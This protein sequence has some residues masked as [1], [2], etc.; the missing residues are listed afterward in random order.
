MKIIATTELKKTT[1]DQPTNKIQFKTFLRHSLNRIFPKLNRVMLIDSLNAETN[2]IAMANYISKNYDLPVSFVVKNEYKKPI[3]ALLDSKIK[4]IG[5]GSL[6]FKLASL[7]SKYILSTHGFLTPPKNQMHINL[8]HGV[9]HKKIKAVR[10][11]SGVSAD[12]TV[13]TSK[14][15]QKMFAEFFEVPKNSVFISGYPRNDVMIH[16]SREKENLLK[17]IT[18]DLRGYK[19]I[20]LW[21]PTYR[22]NPP[23]VDIEMG[24]NGLKLDN[25]FNSKDF[26]VLSFNRILEEQNTICLIKPHYYY[27]L[28]KID[29]FEVLKNILVIND[30][31]VLEQKITLYHLIGCADMLITDFSSVMT[32]FSLLDRPIVC[33]CTDLKEVYKN[34]E[35]YFENI[36]NWLP[37]K[38]FQ[39]QKGFLDFVNQ[40]LTTEND[41]YIE[42]RRKMRNMY[43]QYQD[44]KSAERLANHIFGEKN[45]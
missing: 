1:F 15:T 6:S 11:Y 31:W 9:G 25:L 8:W 12:I 44:D 45:N 27:D 23:G 39:N 41:P 17:D 13:A 32:D 4:V 40:L 38:L 7:T 22:R 21:M 10:G 24:Q 20:I 34:D 5:I 14:F 33:F 28:S 35:L 2:A 37:S 16:A 36:E 30:Q 29:E 18:P 19:K 43:F 42:K 3:V 26:D